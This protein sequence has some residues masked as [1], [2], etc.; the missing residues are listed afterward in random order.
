MSATLARLRFAIQQR[1]WILWLILAAVLILAWF[2]LVA[3][4]PHHVVSTLQHYEEQAN[5]LH[6]APR[7]DPESR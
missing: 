2:V 5:G 3:L 7:G 4:L 1:R 6:E